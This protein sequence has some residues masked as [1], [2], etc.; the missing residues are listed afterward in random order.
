MSTKH[1]VVQHQGAIGIGK[2]GR[3]PSARQ[4]RDTFIR[5]RT[6]QQEDAIALKEVHADRGLVEHQQLRFES[7]HPSNRDTHG[8]CTVQLAW[9]Q[10]G[11]ALGARAGQRSLGA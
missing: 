11:A 1:T 4:Y 9:F 10:L 8:F 3:L 7:E 2:A 5:E 6:Q